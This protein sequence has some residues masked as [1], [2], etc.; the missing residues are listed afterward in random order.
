MPGEN[1]IETHGHKRSF[2]YCP[3][4]EEHELECV[5][6]SDEV[7]P[8]CNGLGE[9][10]NELDLGDPHQDCDQCFGTGQNQY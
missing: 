3:D 5:C 8:K 1:Y 2:G 4:C 7:C 6:G 9:T 10:Y